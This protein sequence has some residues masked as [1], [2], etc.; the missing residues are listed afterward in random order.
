MREIVF[1]AQGRTLPWRVSQ[2]D[3]ARLAPVSASSTG[4]GPSMG[5]Q[6][7]YHKR[8]VPTMLRWASNALL[9]H[10]SLRHGGPAISVG[11]SHRVQTSTMFLNELLSFGWSQASHIARR[12]CLIFF[13]GGGMLDKGASDGPW[14][15]A[16][17]LPGRCQRG[18]L[19]AG[20]PWA[21]CAFGTTKPLGPRG[22]L[23]Q[24]LSSGLAELFF[25]SFTRCH[26]WPDLPEWISPAIWAAPLFA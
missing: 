24:E 5:T 3:T 6:A 25:W 17:A 13:W 12:L 14:T 16:G 11:G 9:V 18:G 7:R 22:R 1:S 20:G 10:M 8:P 4:S 23:S 26:A 21:P 19:R 2:A 15:F